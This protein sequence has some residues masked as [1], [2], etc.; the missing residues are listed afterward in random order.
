MNFGR[1]VWKSLWQHRLS[2]GLAVISIGLG[3]ALLAAV[4][5]LREQTHRAFTEEGLGVDA[6]LGP[7]GSPLQITLNALYHLEEMPGKIPWPYYQKVLGDPIVEG[8]IPF[9]TGHS[10][11]GFRVNAIDARFFTEFE[12]LPGQKFSF[13]AADGGCGRAFEQGGEAVAGA[14]CAR[15]LGLQ[16]GMSFNPTCGIN[17]GDPVHTNDLI[18]FVGILAPTGTPH[19]RAIYIPL[20]AFYTLAGHGDAVQAMADDEAHREISGAFLRIRR[21]RGGVLHPGV[22]DLKYSINQSSAAQLVIPNEV[23]PRLFDIIGWVDRVLVGIALLVTTLALLFLFVALVSAL[24]ERRRDLALLRCLGATR[25]TVCGLILAESLFMS[26][27]GAVCGTCAGH[28]I[29]AVGS[30]FIRVETG[31]RFSAAYLSQ[32]DI[33]VLPAALALGLLAGLVPAVQAYRLGV[34]RN[35]T[36]IS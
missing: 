27:A 32:A 13:A 21:I 22:Q 10:Y 6:V 2:T 25:W 19:D 35:L 3:V 14:E 5:S 16:L 12:Y 26:L 1:I 17:P 29:V 4:V 20:R 33:A 11:A 36:Q 23:L 8:G 15:A 30:T 31:L 9:M 18:R 34:L 24:R 28:A 7:K